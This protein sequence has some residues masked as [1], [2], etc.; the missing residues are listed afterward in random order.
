MKRPTIQKTLKALGSIATLAAVFYLLLTLV[1]N[2]DRVTFV[3]SPALPVAVALFCST[4]LI[5]AGIIKVILSTPVSYGALL[6]I[7]SAAQIYK[8]LPGNVAHFFSRW[9]HLSRQGVKKGENARLILYETLLLVVTYLLVGSVFL[10]TSFRTD[11]AA[12]LSGSRLSVL[13][14]MACA[15]LAVWLVVKKKGVVLQA[16]Q[17]AVILLYSLSAMVFGLILCLL[18][19]SVVPDISGIGFAQYTPG[20]AVSYLAG[21][22]V[23]GSP[24]GVGIREIVFVELFRRGGHEVVLLTQLII[25]FRVAAV[26]AELLMYCVTKIV[27]RSKR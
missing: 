20:F 12:L 6:R 21:F 15:A 8:Y 26:T 10:L 27:L 13:G 16:R 7:N 11:A 3:F 14:G 18:N 4:H 5:Q 24:G 19:I 22:I 23:P 25:L 2:A 17:L 1:E 9:I